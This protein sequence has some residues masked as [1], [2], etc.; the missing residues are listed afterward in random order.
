MLHPGSTYRTSRSSSKH[1]RDRCGSGSPDE[2][3]DVM[4]SEPPAPEPQEP[5]QQP[6]LQEMTMKEPEDTSVPADDPG[7][8]I[9][10]PA[11]GDD[12]T[13]ILPH[14]TEPA[15]GQVPRVVSDS[16]DDLSA[17][18]DQMRWRDQDSGEPDGGFD[19]L[20]GDEPLLGALSGQ[21][22]PY[23][24]DDDFEDFSR[25]VMMT[26]R[27]LS[28]PS[29]AS[30]RHSMSHPCARRRDGAA[31]N[32]RLSTMMTPTPMM[33]NTKHPRNSSNRRQAL[34]GL[35]PRGH[36]LRRH[37]PPRRGPRGIATSLW[38]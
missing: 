12:D 23:A 28:P 3:V 34:Q 25:A 36:D 18:A 21:H 31:E 8:P 20:V 16:P 24:D 26:A 35:G 13:F 7:L 38:P 11:G 9:D 10:D 14:W 33:R 4:R 6:P 15:T 19:D 32:L 5:V 1:L 27:T 17:P 22:D 2:P 29:V 30:K 37:G